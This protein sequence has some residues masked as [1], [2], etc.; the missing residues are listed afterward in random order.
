MLYVKRLDLLL[1]CKRRPAKRTSASS[2]LLQP[3]RLLLLA[4]SL[5]SLGLGS[6]LAHTNQPG[7]TPGLSQPL[8]RILLTAWHLAALDLLEAVLVTQT[9]IQ[10]KRVA[11]MLDALLGTLQLLFAAI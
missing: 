7:L 8:V 11:N 3:V 9:T 5:L 10:W 4:L 6:L 2:H 1:A